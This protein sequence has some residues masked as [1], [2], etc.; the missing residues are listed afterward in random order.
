MAS[1]TNIGFPRQRHR[2]RPVTRFFRHRLLNNLG[3]P[4]TDALPQNTKHLTRRRELPRHLMRAR[5]RRGY[6][7]AVP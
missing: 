4:F 2:L 6:V 5:R 3:D 1:K 7:T